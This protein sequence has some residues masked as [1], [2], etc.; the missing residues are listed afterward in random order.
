MGTDDHPVT[1]TDPDH[2]TPGSSGTDDEGGRARV[3][4]FAKRLLDR[5]EIA[6]DTKEL[7]SAVISSSDKAKNEVLR[8]VAREV[9]SY[10]KELHLREELAKIVKDYSLEVSIRLKPLEPS[11]KAAPD[12]ATPPP[13][14][15]PK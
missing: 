2:P 5:R 8:L 9:R 14:E 13:E 7:V 6:E 4:R 1:E 11:A 3:L 12:L 15:E 10:L